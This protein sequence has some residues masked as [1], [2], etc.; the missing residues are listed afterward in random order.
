MAGVEGQPAGGVQHVD[1]KV[2]RHSRR[3]QLK[4]DRDWRR[5]DSLA[6]AATR[7]RSILV[8]RC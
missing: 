2:V 7:L 1:G 6:A 3:T 8:A 5:S 4:L